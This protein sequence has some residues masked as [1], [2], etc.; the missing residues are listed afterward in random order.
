MR[1]RCCR[2]RGRSCRLWPWRRRAPGA[3]AAVAPPWGSPRRRPA[4][5]VRCKT[6]D[7]P[8]RLVAVLE[9]LTLRRLAC[10]R[11]LCVFWRE[12][13]T[14]PRDSRVYSCSSS[15]ALSRTRTRLSPQS[16]SVEKVGKARLLRVVEGGPASLLVDRP[17]L[18]RVAHL[19]QQ[20]LHDPDRARLFTRGRERRRDS[21][22]AFLSR[23]KKV[24]SSTSLFVGSL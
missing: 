4:R 3:R 1:W 16:L 17:A 19:L 15:R 8:S 7:S 18:R 14:L 23:L 21:I 22:R 5:F 9:R 6:R 11:D 10:T 20:E 24:F 2:L 13:D 12:K